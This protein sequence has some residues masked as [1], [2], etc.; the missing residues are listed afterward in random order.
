[1]GEIVKTPA[2][3]DG[4]VFDIVYVNGDKVRVSE[5]IIFIKYV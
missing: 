3:L 4:T 2:T 1:M 5:I